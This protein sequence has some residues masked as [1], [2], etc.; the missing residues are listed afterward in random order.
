[1]IDLRAS[2]ASAIAWCDEHADPKRPRESLRTP[3]LLSGLLLQDRS[4]IVEEV[5]A[6]R[7]A[8]RRGPGN[9]GSLGAGGRLMV[10]FPNADLSDGAAEDASDR[11]LDVH[12]TPPWDTWVALLEDPNRDPSYGTYLV[13]WVPEPFVELVD[14]GIRVNPEKCIVWLEDAPIANKAELLELRPAWR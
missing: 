3:E 7:V 8:L 2:L 13:A 14:R 12:N 1:M 6:S 11:F 4:W 10:F 5:V 9:V